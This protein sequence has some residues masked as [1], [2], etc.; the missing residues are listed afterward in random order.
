MFSRK[1]AELLAKGI[2]PD[3]IENCMVDLAKAYLDVLDRLSRF[4]VTGTD[5][6]KKCDTGRVSIWKKYELCL[7]C[8]TGHLLERSDVISFF[9]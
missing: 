5:G 3:E 2:F 1:A 6:C 9:E 4:K 7:E 8:Q